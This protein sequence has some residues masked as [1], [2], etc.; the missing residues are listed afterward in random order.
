MLQKHVKQLEQV[1]KQLSESREAILDATGG[2]VCAWA[3]ANIMGTITP[4]LTE[5]EMNA[6]MKAAQEASGG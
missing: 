5:D 2:L 6:I 1:C 3:M 4:A